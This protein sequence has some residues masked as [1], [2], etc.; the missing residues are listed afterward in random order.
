MLY[1]SQYMNSSIAHFG[2]GDKKIVDVMRVTW[3]NGVPQNNL[4][5][6]RNQTILEKQILKGSCPYL[7]VWNGDSYQFA[8]DVLLESSRYMINDWSAFY[9]DMNPQINF[10][11]SF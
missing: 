4:K 2:L 6:K 10:T 3:S 8:T 9:E 1:Q 11:Y 5:L 7:F